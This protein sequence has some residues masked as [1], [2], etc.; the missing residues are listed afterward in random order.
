M[1]SRVSES[2]RTS[3]WSSGGRFRRIG[4]FR[5]HKMDE[6]LKAMEDRDCRAEKSVY[7]STAGEDE[8]GRKHY[9]IFIF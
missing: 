1:D 7:D 5:E 2:P 3:L 9:H 6:V 4:H 8:E